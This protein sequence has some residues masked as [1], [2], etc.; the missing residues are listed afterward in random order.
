MDFCLYK[1]L[2]FLVQQSMIQMLLGS[3]SPGLQFWQ[4]SNK[5]IFASTSS[6]F[7]EFLAYSSE[8]RLH[9]LFAKGSLKVI[10]RGPL[11]LPTLEF[12]T[13]QSAAA[14]NGCWLKYHILKKA[15]QSRRV[16]FKHI[17]VHLKVLSNFLSGLEAKYGR[18]SGWHGHMPTAS[19]SIVH[20][21][22]MWDPM[23]VKQTLSESSNSRLRHCR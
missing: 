1:L 23:S 18:I 2:H 11:P 22:I 15:L 21:G 10:M 17:S 16:V 12:F 14:S 9:S 20:R 6:L 19:G 3:V 5:H 7:L 13:S 4:T 8:E